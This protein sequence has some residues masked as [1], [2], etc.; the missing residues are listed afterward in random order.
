MAKKSAAPAKNA[1]GHLRSLLERIERLA[2]ERKTLAD[3][4][5][6]IFTE[7]KSAGYDVKTMRRMLR[8][9]ALTDAER[10]EQYALDEIYRAALG[11]LD[12]TPLGDAA[13]QR[14]MRPPEPAPDE[15]DS[16]DSGEDEPAGDEA[17]AAGAAAP[18]ADDLTAARD[19]GMAA[20]RDGVPVTR[21]PYPAD[22]RLRG[23]WDEGWCAAAG[24][25]GMDIPPAFRRRSPKPARGKPG[26]GE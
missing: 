19:A 25:D 11:M 18:S 15:G 10:Q 14:L 16:G 4:I 21:N 5:K 8:E 22:S 23:A 20:A 24:S 12:G 13:R 2:E 17:P 26:K 7:A 6:E 1:D 9:R 3:D